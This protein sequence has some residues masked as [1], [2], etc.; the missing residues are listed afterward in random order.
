MIDAK[1]KKNSDDIYFLLDNLPFLSY[2]KIAK[3]DWHDLRNR[4]SAILW[5]GFYPERSIPDSG[6]YP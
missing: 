1:G 2:E 3:E 4:E 5:S 6:S